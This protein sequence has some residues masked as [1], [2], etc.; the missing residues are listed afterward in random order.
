MSRLKLCQVAL[1]LKAAALA[2]AKTGRTKRLG[3]VFLDYLE[4]I[5]EQLKNFHKALLSQ[6]ET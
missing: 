4:V 6:R 5:R 2:K 3:H 1:R